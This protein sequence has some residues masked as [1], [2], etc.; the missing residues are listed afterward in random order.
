MITTKS[1]PI[2]MRIKDTV[3]TILAFGSTSKQ[4]VEIPSP[5]VP[6]PART[7]H[8]PQ[9]SSDLPE[10]PTS[11]RKQRSASPIPV[12]SPEGVHKNVLNSTAV[13]S[14][15]DKYDKI[16]DIAKQVIGENSDNKLNKSMKTSINAFLRNLNI[17]KI[18]GI[19][20]K[21]ADEI[22]KEF[23]L[24]FESYEAKRKESKR[25]SSDDESSK[26]APKQKVDEVE[27]PFKFDVNPT[28][29]F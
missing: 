4:P 7:S 16:V 17:P 15:S 24:R 11:N 28:Y 29:R 2:K 6:Q 21:P 23:A 1:K 10:E 5:R 13:N 14:N 22:M 25:K 20:R 18:N 12:G 8:A 3:K 19:L 9:L 26:R 27:K